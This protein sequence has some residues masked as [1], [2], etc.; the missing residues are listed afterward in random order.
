MIGKRKNEESFL[1]LLDRLRR[2]YRCHRG[3]HLAV[4][5]DASHTSKMVKNYVQD[6]G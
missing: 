6:S 3:L 2:T 4:D 1:E 5:N